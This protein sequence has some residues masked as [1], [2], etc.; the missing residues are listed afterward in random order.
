[1]SKVAEK[2]YVLGSELS[3]PFRLGIP[4]LRLRKPKEIGRAIAGA[5][6]CSIW[7]GLERGTTDLL[8]QEALRASKHGGHQGSHLGRLLLLHTPRLESIPTL[9]DLFTS[10]AWGA[11]SFSALPPKELAQAL[12]AEHAH[13]LIIGGFVDPKTQALIL[14][15]GSFKRFSVP[16]SIFKPSGAGLAPDATKFAVTDS[17]Q[18]IRLGD[19]EASTDSVLYEVDPEYRHRVNAKRREEDKSFGASLRRLRVFRG[20]RQTDFKPIPARTISRIERGETREP[21]G[22]TLELIAKRLQVEP[23]EITTY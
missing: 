19:Y 20:L 5:S 6:R 8:L 14:Y 12:T 7:I 13:D 11:S 15:R 21:H 2:V 1:M 22:R 4:A 9:E 23:G 3:R 17:G 18:T 16:L 10:V